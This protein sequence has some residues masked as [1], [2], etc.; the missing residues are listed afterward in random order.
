MLGKLLLEYDVRV[1]VCSPHK[2]IQISEEINCALMAG[3]IPPG[4]VQCNLTT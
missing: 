1:R 2:S 4:T 3:R